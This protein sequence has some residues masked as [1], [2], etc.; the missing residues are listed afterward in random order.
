MILIHKAKR[1]AK[2]KS[3]RT[4]KVILYSTMFMDSVF[5]LM[6][7]FDEDHVGEEI[8]FGIFILSVL[9]GVTLSLLFTLQMGLFFFG[10][11]L[12]LCFNAY[13][14]L[15]L[16]RWHIRKTQKRLEDFDYDTIT[17]DP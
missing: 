5:R 14:V 8:V 16:V 9:V 2:Q 17:P 7:W 13:I 11:G 1:F 12:V 15:Y 6:A 10:L 3:V 4:F